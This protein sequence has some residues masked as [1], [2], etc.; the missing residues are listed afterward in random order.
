MAPECI[1]I[2]EVDKAQS[3]KIFSCRLNRLLHAV[4]A[5]LG[6]QTLRDALAAE[7]IVDFSDADDI[8][9]CLL[10]RVEHGFS[11]RFDSVVVTVC[12]ADELSFFLSDVRSCNDTADFPLV[13]HG[14]LTGNLA[15]MIQRLQSHRL[16]V[17]ADLQYGIRRGIDDQFSVFD[18]ALCQLIEDLRSARRLITDDLSAGSFFQLVDQFFRKSVVG[19]RNERL[20]RVNSHHLPVAGHGVFSV[21]RLVQ[22][23][24]VTLCL[25]LCHTAEISHAEAAQVRDFKA[26]L[27]LPDVAEGIDTDIPKLLRIRHRPDSERIQDDQKNTVIFS[28]TLYSF[29]FNSAQTFHDRADNIFLSVPEVRRGRR[30]LR[31]FPAPAP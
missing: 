14:Q 10:H 5:A 12:G 31:Y 16:L 22:S 2:D 19:E 20:C 26:S 13:F 24:G 8:I 28:H 25:I 21:A 6:F 23:S 9:S 11:R 3:G 15:V 7:N 4:D 30:A 17:A 18:L 29:L 1:E 27:T